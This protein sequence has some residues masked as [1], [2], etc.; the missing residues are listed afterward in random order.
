MKI[1]ILISLLVLSLVS[2]SK[3]DP[4]FKEG[5]VVYVFP[6]YTTRAII[7][8]NHIGIDSDLKVRFDNGVVRR[9]PRSLVCDSTK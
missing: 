2:C 7:L 3:E 4:K 8:N 1:Y 9:I 5:N 6:D